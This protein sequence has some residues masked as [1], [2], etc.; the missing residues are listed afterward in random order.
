MSE[1]KDG[2]AFW[3]AT[4]RDTGEPKRTKNGDKYMTGNITINGVK[5]GAT[6]FYR[7]PEN[8]KN[9]KEPDISISLNSQQQAAA[10][11]PQ[12]PPEQEVRV[13]DIPF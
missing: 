13:E 8:K 2:G 6:L 9:P 3:W 10:P 11:A 5:M 7:K 12:R 4:D 1:Q